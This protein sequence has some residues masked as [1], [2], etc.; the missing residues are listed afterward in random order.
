MNS[1]D[2]AP[3]GYI[4][5][6]PERRSGLKGSRGKFCVRSNTGAGAKS[7]VQPF[8]PD[9]YRGARPPVPNFPPF[10]PAV[11]S[12]VGTNIHPHCRSC[13]ILS[14][15][16]LVSDG[17]RLGEVVLILGLNKTPT[18][19]RE[20]SYAAT[21]ENSS[22]PDPT[23]DIPIARVVRCVSRSSRYL[24]WFTARRNGHEIEPR[25]SSHRVCTMELP[26]FNPRDPEA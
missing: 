24:S 10:E 5:E 1:S 4:V 6:S 9:R 23:T 11:L 20:G 17:M 12:L 15:I 16:H 2:L 21:S 19:T 26:A 3:P 18:Q 22:Q 8:N 13:S 14:S 25:Q 7:R